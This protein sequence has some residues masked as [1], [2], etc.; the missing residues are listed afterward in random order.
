MAPVLQGKDRLGQMPDMVGIHVRPPEVD[1]R[2]LP[3]HGDLDGDF[4]RRSVQETFLLQP[5]APS[6]PN[7]GST[8]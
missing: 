4:A 3:A 1:D 7:T 5:P 2:M 6:L 8:P